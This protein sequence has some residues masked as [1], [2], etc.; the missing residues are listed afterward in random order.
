MLAEPGT[1]NPE[2]LGLDEFVIRR[3]SG[4]Q[5]FTSSEAGTAISLFGRM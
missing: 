1:Q 2:L 3:F 5:G 4:P